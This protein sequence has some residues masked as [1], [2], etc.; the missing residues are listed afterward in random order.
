MV[1]FITSE[2]INGMQPIH[3]AALYGNNHAIEKLV[4]AGIHKDKPD[5]NGNTPLHLAT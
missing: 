3:H 1:D 2:D 5:R 4:S